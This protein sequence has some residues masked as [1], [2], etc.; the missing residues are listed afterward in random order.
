MRTGIRLR[1]VFEIELRIPSRSTQSLVPVVTDLLRPQSIIACPSK[2]LTD[3]VEVTSMACHALETQLVRADGS[4]IAAIAFGKLDRFPPPPARYG[5]H[6]AEITPQPDEPQSVEDR[7]LDY[8]ASLIE[9]WGQP[10]Y[11]RP[12][13]SR[14]VQSGFCARLKEI[15]AN[16]CGLRNDQPAADPIRLETYEYAKGCYYACWLE[17][18]GWRQ[19]ECN[20]QTAGIRFI[21]NYT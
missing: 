1:W 12:I 15:V 11:P 9:K 13:D 19:I 8:V 3:D 17:E 20:S 21:V 4:Y 16:L 2:Q 6:I 14:P 18:Y 5:Q 7:F 10:H